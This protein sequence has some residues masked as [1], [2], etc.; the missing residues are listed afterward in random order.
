MPDAIHPAGVSSPATETRRPGAAARDA[1]SPP[2]R[3]AAGEPEPELGRAGRLLARAQERPLGTLAGPAE[4]LDLARALAARIRS[5]PEAALAAHAGVS[6][7]AA[8]ATLYP[9]GP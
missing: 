9:A 4:A 7:P 5:E 3:R 8:E 1:G 2:S 6:T